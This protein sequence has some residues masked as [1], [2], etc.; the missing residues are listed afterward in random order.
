MYYNLD[1]IL[2]RFRRTK[3]ITAYPK[4]DVTSGQLL[5]H[6]DVKHLLHHIDFLQNK[7][8]IATQAIESMVRG[9][10]SSATNEREHLLD[11]I[12]HS[13]KTGLR[14]LRDLDELD[15]EQEDA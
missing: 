10:D 13:N 9:S 1:L 6:S 2:E 14:A 7:L 12:R 8:D 11:Y 4:E 5:K 15:A 3:K